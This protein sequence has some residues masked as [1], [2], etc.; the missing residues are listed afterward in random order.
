MKRITSLLNDVLNKEAGSMARDLG[1]YNVQ[2]QGYS[3]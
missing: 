2:V 1:M 3:E